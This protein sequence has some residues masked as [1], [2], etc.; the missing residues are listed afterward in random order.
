MRFFATPPDVDHD[1]FTRDH[2]NITRDHNSTIPSVADVFALYGQVLQ[3]QKQF[4]EAEEKFLT[5]QKLAP[6]N[7]TFK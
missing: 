1:N 5:A 7:V 4:V 2:D 3:D 6:D